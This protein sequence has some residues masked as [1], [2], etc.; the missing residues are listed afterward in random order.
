MIREFGMAVIESA[1]GTAKTSPVAGTE[2]VYMR[3]DGDDSFTVTA[4]P[5]EQEIA[6]GGGFAVGALM[7]ASQTAVTGRLQMKLYSSQA[8]FWLNWLMARINTGQTSPWTTT[9]P[10]G[11]LASLSLYHA[12]AGPDNV[13][14]K[15]TRYAGC[16]ATGFTLSASDQ[17]PFWQLS[18]DITAQRP[19]GNAQDASSDP[20]ATEFPA[21]TDSQLPTDP[22]LWRHTTFSLGGSA[23]TELSSFQLQVRNTLD[24][25][26]YTSRFLTALNLRG[27]QATFDANVLLRL[28]TPDD[29]ASYEALSALAS[30]LALADGTRTTTFQL[31]GN[32]RPTQAT[33]Q[34]AL[35]RTY[36]W[37]L[38]GR[39]L[40]DGAAA[41]DAS[42]TVV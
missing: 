1:Y 8:L 34:L 18:I 14:Y 24:P 22:Y 35:G 30:T 36:K 29:R 32:N 17:S 40:W 3:L 26:Y 6:R 19:V 12:Y 20:N 16:K 23:R 5:V 10:V 39:N 41:E 21:P 4:D 25:N 28:T 27:R 2:L 42:F 31:R 15:R 13:T 9:E 37:Q 7:F 33:R 38:Q 11:D